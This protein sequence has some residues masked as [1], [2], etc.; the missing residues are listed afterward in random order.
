VSNSGSGS[1]HADI[2][3]QLE[4]IGRRRHVALSVHQ[5]VVVP[6]FLRITDYVAALPSRL[7]G[8]FTDQLDVFELPLEAR[9]YTIRPHGIRD[10]TPIQAASGCASRSARLLGSP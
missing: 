9:S 8:Q 4:K 10:T 3:E 1:F 2:D 5:F 6:M 7:A